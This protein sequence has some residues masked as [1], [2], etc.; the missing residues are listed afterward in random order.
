MKLNE[1]EYEINVINSNWTLKKI[2]FRIQMEK[3]A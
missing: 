3:Y 1:L 2:F